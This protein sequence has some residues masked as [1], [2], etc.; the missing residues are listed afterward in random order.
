MD[1]FELSYANDQEEAPI[2][3]FA[4]CQLPTGF[5]LLLFGLPLDPL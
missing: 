2:L 3:F 4:G 1:H 5:F